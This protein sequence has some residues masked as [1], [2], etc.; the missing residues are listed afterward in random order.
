MPMPSAF[1]Q[2]PIKCSCKI[3]AFRQT[4]YLSV[5]SRQNISFVKRKRVWFICLQLLC[6]LVFCS[7]IA[8]HLEPV[9]VVVAQPQHHQHQK[10]TLNG[11]FRL[12]ENLLKHTH[13]TYREQRVSSI[14]ASEYGTFC[15]IDWQ[16]SYIFQQIF[17]I[18]CHSK[19]S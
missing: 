13:I 2:H 15:K 17:F 6:H 8:I 11:I 19:Q 3:H 4:F 18:I 9:P 5:V 1:F 16:F 7:S 12:L 10:Q 14:P